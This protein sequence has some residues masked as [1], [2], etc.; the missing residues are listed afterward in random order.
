[1][2]PKIYV[3]HQGTHIFRVGVLAECQACKNKLPE[4]TRVPVEISTV[5]DYGQVCY[6]AGHD[7]GWD[8]ASYETFI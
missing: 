7:A 6:D 8:A 4:L 3:C 5:E 2:A 1:M